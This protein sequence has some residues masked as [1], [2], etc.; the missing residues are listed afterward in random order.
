MMPGWASNLRIAS[1]LG[2]ALASKAIHLFAYLGGGMIFFR[3]R[4]LSMH[5]CP[6]HAPVL[7]T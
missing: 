3:K 7:D 4:P 2:D 1:D 5:R 6:V